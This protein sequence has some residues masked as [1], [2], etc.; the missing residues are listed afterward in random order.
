M[1]IQI[2]CDFDGTI[3]TQDTID[4]FL[5]AFSLPGW[6]KL[7]QKWFCGEIGSKECLAEHFKLIPRPKA[8]ELEQFLD[9]IGVDPEFAA[10]HSFVKENNIDFYIVSDGLDFFIKTVLENHGLGDIK[11]FSNVLTP[12]FTLEFPNANPQCERLSGTCKCGVINKF[13]RPGAKIIYIGDGISDFCGSKQADIV[14]A[15]GTLL[16]HCEHAI[17]FKSFADIKDYIICHLM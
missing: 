14:F 1:D 10:F 5:P 8:G 11:F 3:T 2:F 12:E 16:K 17:G 6:E 13:T 4:R 9:T 7:S 15:K